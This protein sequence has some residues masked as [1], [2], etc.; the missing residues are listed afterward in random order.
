MPPQIDP[1]GYAAHEAANTRADIEEPTPW[2]ACVIAV[3]VALAL[4]A[5]L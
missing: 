2:I 3:L 5:L 1:F 4:V